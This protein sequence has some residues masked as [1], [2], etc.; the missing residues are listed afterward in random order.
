MLREDEPFSEIVDKFGV[1]R[2]YLYQVKSKMRRDG[3]LDEEM[4][5]EEEEPEV[6]EDE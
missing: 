4:E 3:E 5:K 1:S 6:E 2:P